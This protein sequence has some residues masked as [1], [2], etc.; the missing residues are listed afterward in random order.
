M[1][2][3]SLDVTDVTRIAREA[4]RAQAAELHVVGVTVG[5]RDGDYAEVIIDLED[6]GKEPC[7]V[8]IGVF[9]NASPASVRDEIVKRLERHVREHGN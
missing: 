3:A 2:S 9:R 5:D 7:R 4:V 1:E 6:C 8:S